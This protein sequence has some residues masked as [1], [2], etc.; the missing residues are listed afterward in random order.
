MT[1]I[2]EMIAG[3]N[4]FGQ[5]VFFLILLGLIFVFL[6]RAMFFVT[7]LVRGWPP[8]NVTDTMKFLSTG[9]VEEDDE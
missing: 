8:E 3:W 2:L 4:P 1:A 7:V 9:D 6:H 5:A